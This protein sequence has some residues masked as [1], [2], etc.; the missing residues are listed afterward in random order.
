MK[1]NLNLKTRDIG[2]G[3]QG[4]VYAMDIWDNGTTITL[5]YSSY[6]RAKARRKSSRGFE[7]NPMGWK[8][9]KKPR[10]NNFTSQ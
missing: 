8:F 1:V 6:R 7:R 9:N 4:D 3:N 10:K 5:R 2:I